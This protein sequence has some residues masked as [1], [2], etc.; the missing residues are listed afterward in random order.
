MIKIEREIT[1]RREIIGILERA[2]T[3][4]IAFHGSEYPYVVPVS[5]GMTEDGD[6]LYLWFHGARL[7]LKTELIARDPRVSFECDIFLGTEEIKHG[8]TTRYESVIG[9]GRIEAASGDRAVR[10]L[11]AICDHYGYTDFPL[12]SCGALSATAVYCIN[13]DSLS[14]KRNL[15]KKSN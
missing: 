9:F 10:G 7:G 3:L 11:R 5:F 12:E 14:G 1:D 4:R 8:I 6:E 13:V 15:P 2:D